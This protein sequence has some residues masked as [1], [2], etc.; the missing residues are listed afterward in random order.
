[1]SRAITLASSIVE[2]N[3][4]LFIKFKFENVNNPHNDCGK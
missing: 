4:G 2:I 3:E 1:M